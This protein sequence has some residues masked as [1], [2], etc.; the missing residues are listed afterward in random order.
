MALVSTDQCWISAGDLIWVMLPGRNVSLMSPPAM[1]L[2]VDVPAHLGLLWGL[3]V[4]DVC[5]F[6]ECFVAGRMALLC[7]LCWKYVKEMFS[8]MWYLDLSH[9]ELKT[10]EQS[11]APDLICPV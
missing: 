6:A 10:A 2:P 7:I 11:P 1:L 8:S 5:R 3:A 4:G 9:F